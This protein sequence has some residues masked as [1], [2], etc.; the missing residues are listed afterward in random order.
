MSVD[1]ALQLYITKQISLL[2]LTFNVGCREQYFLI[3]FH[4]QRNH[5]RANTLSLI[6]FTFICASDI[7]IYKIVQHQEFS[8]KNY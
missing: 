2:M 1:A 7:K 4:R 8:V 3:K 6:L 5:F